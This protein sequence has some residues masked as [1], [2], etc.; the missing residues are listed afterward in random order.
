MGTATETLFDSA[1]YTVLTTTGSGSQI[2]DALRNAGATEGAGAFTAS[3]VI[4]V[5]VQIPVWCTLYGGMW[6]NGATVTGNVDVGVMDFEGN[7]LA[8]S[9]STAMSGTSTIQTVSFSSS[10][11]VPPGTY[12]IAWV[13][14]SNSSTFERYGS[15]AQLNRACGCTSE[16]AFPIPS[17]WSP[18]GAQGSIPVVGVS[19]NSTF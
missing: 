18:A 4:Y 16:S 9:G 12:Y 8:H 5:P 15:N 7:R 3:T 11:V 6:I 14:D 13:P 2:A 10:V 1:S 19:T 17:T